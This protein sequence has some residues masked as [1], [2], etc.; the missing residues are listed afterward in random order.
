MSSL[1]LLLQTTLYFRTYI[2]CMSVSSLCPLAVS[3]TLLFCVPCFCFLYIHT[4]ILRNY[5]FC[6]PTSSPY[7][8][9]PAPPYPLPPP[10]LRNPA[11]ICVYVF[12]CVWVWGSF[13]IFWLPDYMIVGE[14]IRLKHARLPYPIY[15]CITN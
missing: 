3:I 5:P 10:P 12:I 14:D 6:I 7:H 11:S 8:N 15:D 13:A 1:L 9:S 4:N 2:I